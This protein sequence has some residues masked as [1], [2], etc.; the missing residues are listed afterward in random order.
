[1]RIVRRRLRREVYDSYYSSVYYILILLTEE[2]IRLN[3]IQKE[4]ALI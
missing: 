4:H 3:E 2:M 1:M